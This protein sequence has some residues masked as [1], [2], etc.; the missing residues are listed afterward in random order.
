MSE[1]IIDIPAG[2]WDYDPTNYPEWEKDS[3]ANGEMIRDMFDDTTEEYLI[4]QIQA[5]PDLDTDGT[6]YFEAYGY[7]VTADG[8]EVQLCFYHSAKE[9][10]ESW[11]AAYTAEKSGD[12]VTDANQDELDFIEWNE[13]ITNLGWAA[14]DHIRVKL[15]RCAVDD[16]TTVVGDYGVTHFRIR[17]PIA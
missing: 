3:G 12:Y 9:K 13:T 4:G 17:I 11:D 6:V 5:P 10:G 7:A 14:S 15:S 2:A 1:F 16:G 8:N